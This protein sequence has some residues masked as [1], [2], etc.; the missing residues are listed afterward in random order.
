MSRRISLSPN[1]IQKL[2]TEAST[3]MNR[4][5]IKFDSITKLK[6]SRISDGIRLE[7][8]A[9]LNKFPD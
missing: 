9:E 8:K 6:G 3:E 7:S 2:P 5:S 4:K 1:Q